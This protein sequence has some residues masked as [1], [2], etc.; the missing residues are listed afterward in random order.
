MATQTVGEITI[1]DLFIKYL[2]YR[3]PFDLIPTVSAY[4][5][6]YIQYSIC[7]KSCPMAQELLKL[8]QNDSLR[9]SSL[10]SENIIF[11]NR[12]APQSSKRGKVCTLVCATFVLAASEWVTNSP[13]EVW[14]L[15]HRVAT[16]AFSEVSH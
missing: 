12:V 8:G 3:A 7:H 6:H 10:R 15:L 13:N 11:A 5:A 16:Y 14:T 4:L 9:F 1:E 2:K